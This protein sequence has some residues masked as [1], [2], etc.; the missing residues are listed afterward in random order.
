MTINDQIAR[1]RTTTLLPKGVLMARVT[2]VADEV[3]VVVG[4]NLADFTVPLAS[5]CYGSVPGRSRVEHARSVVRDEGF[6]L[7]DAFVQEVDPARGRATTELVA[8]VRPTRPNE[9]PGVEGPTWADGRGP[10][11]ARLVQHV[12]AAASDVLGDMLD[13]GALDAITDSLTERLRAAD[14]LR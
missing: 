1:T 8:R 14:Y 6:E 3:R 9:R 7:V 13:A 12:Q 5:A 10:T 2:F 11:Y 4:R